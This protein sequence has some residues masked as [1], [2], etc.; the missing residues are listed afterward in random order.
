MLREQRY[1]VLGYFI[2]KKTK[3]EYA[4]ERFK[5]KHNFIP[6]KTKG[7]N[8][9]NHGTFDRGDGTRRRVD[10]GKSKSVST[11]T[12][13]GSD[14]RAPRSAMV[15]LNKSKNKESKYY[16]DKE[17]FKLKNGKRREAILQHEVG[18]D[19]FHSAN[20]TD[21][22]ESETS[23]NSTIDSMVK[24]AN[25]KM[26]YKS[27]G[28][29][30]SDKELKEVENA[31]K[32]SYKKILQES[33]STSQKD[34]PDKSKQKLRR[35][36]LKILKN[37]CGKTPHDNTMEKEADLHA[38]NKTSKKDFKKGITEYSKKK[39]KEIQK[40][41]SRALDKYGVKGKDKEEHMKKNKTT[42]N[43]ELNEDNKN[44][45]KVLKDKKLLE[46]SKKVYN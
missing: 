6:D 43:K 10:M 7:G 24:N 34:L 31:T 11:Y 29:E 2:E 28:I 20:S 32:N 41:T 14:M 16:L 26:M 30:I 19:K 37:K 5:K 22:S 45:I 33:R 38:V 1:E 46:K 44:R 4:R 8:D 13:D 9:P 40:E 3:E 12:L 39:S 36:M 27:I 25:I 17:F 18:H 15:E 35:E 42:L 21:S 23:T